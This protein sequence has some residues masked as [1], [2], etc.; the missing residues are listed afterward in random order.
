VTITMSDRDTP[1]NVTFRRGDLLTSGAQALVNPVN[2]VGVMG[3][4]LAKQ[5]R[6]RYP[7]MFTDYQSQCRARLYQPGVPCIWR[8]D[9]QP[10]IVNF[11][12]KGHWRDPTQLQWIRAGLVIL[13]D[14]LRTD[15]IRS[16][17]LPPLGCGLGGLSWPDVRDLILEHLSGLPT[18]VL[19]YGSP[20]Q[21]P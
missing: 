16:I 1:S 19:V 10:L 3:A 15:G 4:G 2:C 11:P 20:P 5:F 18:D 8:C 7:V 17:A 14:L 12:T 9:G 21:R 13:A 6:D